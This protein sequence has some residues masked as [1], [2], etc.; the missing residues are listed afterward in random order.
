MSDKAKPEKRVVKIAAGSEASSE[1]VDAM[2]E[3]LKGAFGQEPEIER[4]PDVKVE[5]T[6]KGGEGK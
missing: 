4:L 1:A 2:A 6:D 5:Q 3:L